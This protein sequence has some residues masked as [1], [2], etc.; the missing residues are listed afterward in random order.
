MLAITTKDGVTVKVTQ[1]IRG[2]SKLIEEALFD[3]NDEEV[4]AIDCKDVNER[5]LKLIIDYC[6]HFEFKKTAT[7]IE[8][9]LPSKD[10]K[11]FIKDDFE[12]TFIEAID[13]DGQC[14]LLMA[15]NY[16]NIPAIFELCCAS[17]AAFFKGKDFDKI[18]G[19]FGL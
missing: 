1:D 16:F 12:R 2:M 17:I 19:D 13:L 5:E 15:A 4:V 8:H 18:K 10:P 9:P 3:N 6:N 14:E 11:E 7:D